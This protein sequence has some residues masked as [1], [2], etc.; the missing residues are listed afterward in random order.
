[1]ARN[2]R[3]EIEFC[4]VTYGYKPD[5]PVLKNVSFRLKPG[6]TLAVVGA[7]GS[8]KSTILKLCRSFEPSLDVQQ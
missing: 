3:G 4:D 7:T 2:L 5:E 6:E 1:M 8:G